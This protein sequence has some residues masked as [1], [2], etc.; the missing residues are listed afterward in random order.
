MNDQ[1]FRKKSME[2]ITSPENLN[3]YIRV[4]SP[5]VWM[6]LCAVILIL[7]GVC[8]WG[9]FGR[10]DTTVQTAAVSDGTRT[11]CYIAEED[12]ASVEEGM[13]VT[14][15]DTDY[16]ITAISHEPDQMTE[17]DAYLMHVLNIDENSWV[18]EAEIDG[19]LPEGLYQGDITIESVSPM[20]FI[21]N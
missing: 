18:Y 16:K 14:I 9:M 15:D 17:E 20:S 12:I 19:S 11:V 4:A 8:C 13:T 7:I 6:T 3:D 10:L 2:K 21:T 5:G 1:L